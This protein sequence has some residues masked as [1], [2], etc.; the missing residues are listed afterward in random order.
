MQ[1]LSHMCTAATV[2]DVTDL[3]QYCLQTAEP[4]KKS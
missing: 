2:L 4:S 3:G 1:S